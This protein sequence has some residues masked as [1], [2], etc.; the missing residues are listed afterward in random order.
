MEEMLYG[1]TCANIG[2]IVAMLEWA[3]RVAKCREGLG[4]P[5][6]GAA[7]IGHWRLFQDSILD[8]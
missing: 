4:V 6:G 3:E 8:T 7:D 1:K 2:G 5:R